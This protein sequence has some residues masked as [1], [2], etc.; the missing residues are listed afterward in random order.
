ME[1]NELLDDGIEPELRNWLLGFAG[2]AGV[3]SG[4]PQ[5]FANL[6]AQCISGT[7]EDRASLL[8]A[9][10]VGSRSIVRGGT[11]IVGPAIVAEDVTIASSVEINGPTYIGSGCSVSHG[12][13]IRGSLI[14]NRT[15]IGAGAYIA[16]SLVGANC[17][18]G[19]RALLGVDPAI[20]LHDGSRLP[21]VAVGTYSRIGAGAILQSGS[22]LAE[23]AAVEN[24]ALVFGHDTP[25]SRG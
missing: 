16:D 25:T 11:F 15:N 9:V 14:L 5:L 6:Q 1:V 4:L 18:V 10:H 13:T 17:I 3:Y 23:R 20:T 8:G 7:V 21:F 2:L 12:A 19:P 24:G 22:K